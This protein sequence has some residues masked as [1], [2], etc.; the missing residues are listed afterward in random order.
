MSNLYTYYDATPEITPSGKVA[1]RCSICNARQSSNASLMLRSHRL[2]TCHNCGVEFDLVTQENL[3]VTLHEDSVD[4][5]NDSKLFDTTWFHYSNRLKVKTAEE[6]IDAIQQNEIPVHIGTKK[7]AMSL[8]KDTLRTSSDAPTRLP[9]KVRLLPST[10]IIPG[11][12]YDFSEWEDFYF[13]ERSPNS[14]LRY[15]NAWESPGQISLF[16]DSRSIALV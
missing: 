15:L 12:A 2:V 10:K 5:L 16:V 3:E 13:I 14:A 6:W 9:W 7:S 11:L 8:R 4:F 1:F